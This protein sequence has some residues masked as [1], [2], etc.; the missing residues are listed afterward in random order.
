MACNGLGVIAGRHGD[1]PGGP[2][3]RGQQRQP[4]GRAPFLEGPCGLQIIQLQEHPGPGRAGDRLAFERWG[5]QHGARDTPGGS[6][7]IGQGN[8]AAFG[9]R[10]A[11]RH[12]DGPI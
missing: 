9:L 11:H 5:A 2:F 7:D 4:I 1:G 8:G 12:G 10:R 3:P 6:A